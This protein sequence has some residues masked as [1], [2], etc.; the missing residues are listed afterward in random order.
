MEHFVSNSRVTQDN[1]GHVKRTHLEG[2]P[3]MMDNLNIGENNNIRK[4]SETHR[5]C[6]KTH[7]SIRIIMKKTLIGHH[8][9]ILK[10]GE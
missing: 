4:S 9:I 10:T 5:K 7:D 1:W 2:F 8:I 3:L 6:L